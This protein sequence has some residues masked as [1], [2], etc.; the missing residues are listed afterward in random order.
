[1]PVAVELNGLFPGLGPGRGAPGAKHRDAAHRDA[2]H[3][4]RPGRPG[5]GRD[6]PC[7][8]AA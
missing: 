3:R 5:V 8:L 7:A 4:A 1:M 2:A 6:R